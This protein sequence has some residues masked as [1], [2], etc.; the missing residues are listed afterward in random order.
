M[1]TS[2]NLWLA[3]IE[4]WAARFHLDCAIFAD[5]VVGRTLNYFVEQPSM[6][7]VCL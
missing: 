3:D 1:R 5:V 6:I 2:S 4:K 7:P